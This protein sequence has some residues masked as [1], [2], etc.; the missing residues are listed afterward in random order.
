[1]GELDIDTKDQR[2]EKT[3]EG[4]RGGTKSNSK[5]V[6][7]NTVVPMRMEAMRDVSKGLSR[8]CGP[9]ASSRMRRMPSLGASG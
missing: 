4:T 9:R 1:M 7:V 8:G 3:G 6:P 2:L 5:A